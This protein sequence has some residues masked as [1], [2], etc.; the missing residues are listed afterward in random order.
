MKVEN[1]EC[2]PLVTIICTV[3]NHEKYIRQALDSFIMQ[4][5]SF[6]Y[7]VYVQDDCQLITQKKLLWSMKRNILIL[8]RP[9]I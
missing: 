5:C 9:S 3:Y 8:S 7:N 4:K 2:S 1:K 6:K